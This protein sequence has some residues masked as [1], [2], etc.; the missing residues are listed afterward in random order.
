MP[1]LSLFPRGPILP[2]AMLLA[3][4]PAASWIGCAPPP[5]DAPR[6]IDDLAHWSMAAYEPGDPEADAVRAEAVDNLLAWYAEHPDES[7]AGGLLTDL[8]RDDIAAF[9]D[10]LEGDPD[11]AEA[12]GIYLLRRLP[13]ELA[14]VEAI[15][16]DSDQISRYPGTYVSYSRDYD[17][18]T[19]CFA[20]GDCDAVDWT[21]HVED[22]EVISEFVYSMESG[23]RRWRLDREAGDDGPDVALASRTYMP[24]PALTN[25]PDVGGFEQNYQVEV[26]VPEAGGTVIHL[27]AFWNE[28]WIGIGND[29]DA[30]WANQYLDSLQDWD[31]RTAEICTEES[32]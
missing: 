30:F 15:Y 12:V 13:C 22:L 2:A 25:T 8:D 9:R 27:Y 24:A 29:D 28:A 4:A 7:E 1:S 17:G 20:A 23:L 11:P 6:T 18:D 14:Q 10:H 5:P 16:L 21:A 19:A 26:F 3:G 31:D 32:G